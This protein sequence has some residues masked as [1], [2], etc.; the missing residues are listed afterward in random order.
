MPSALQPHLKLF[1][2]A[3]VADASVDT[4]ELYGAVLDRVVGEFEY[5]DDGRDALVKAFMN[6]PSVVITDVRLPMI[7]GY[8]LCRLLRQDLATRAV[9]IIMVTSDSSAAERARADQAGADVV[10]VKPVLPDALCGALEDCGRR[11]VDR[12]PRTDGPSPGPLQT[13]SATVSDPSQIRRLSRTFERHHTTTPALKVPVAIC[14][15]CDCRL[16][17]RSSYVGGVAAHNA[18]QWDEF[19]C[20]RS[21]GRFQ[22][23]HRTRKLRRL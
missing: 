12:P 7:D 6:P 4:R 22:Y 5:V 23:R 11:L 2:R 21:C 8:A 16:N 15:V 20:P 18:E 14:P 1:P 9:P 3:L 17:Y 10:L 13:A 19:E